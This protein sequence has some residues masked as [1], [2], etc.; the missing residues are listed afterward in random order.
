MQ[1]SANDIIYKFHE[2]YEGIV[3]E[4]NTWAPTVREWEWAKPAA[5][6]RIV[7]LVGTDIYPVLSVTQALMKVFD[8]Q[9]FNTVITE[10][11]NLLTPQGL[12][13]LW[14]RVRPAAS[15]TSDDCPVRI[16]YVESVSVTKAGQIHVPALVMTA[17]KAVPISSYKLSW[18]FV[19]FKAPY[20]MTQEYSVSG[21]M[22]PRDSCKVEDV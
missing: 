14:E 9:S 3:M 20:K 10:S 18:F 19:V 16:K 5:G 4:H 13:Q 2:A 11:D 17:R 8:P 7:P 22:I 6:I 12:D 15:I 21:F 1:I